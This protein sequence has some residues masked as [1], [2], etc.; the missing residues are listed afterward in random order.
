VTINLPG[1][2]ITH[3]DMLANELSLVLSPAPTPTERPQ[4]KTSQ[5]QRPTIKLSDENLIS[6]QLTGTIDGFGN[7][8][9]RYFQGPN[10][11]I[12][13]LD[14]DFL[15]VQKFITALAARKE[16]SQYVGEKYILDVLFDWFRERYIGK[17]D[18]S[19]G[20]IQYFINRASI[21]ITPLHIAI[22]LSHL[23]MEQSF[24]IGLVT[25]DFY[26]SA[27]FDAMESSFR[28]K[29]PEAAADSLKKIREDYQGIVFAHVTVLAE[30]EHAKDIAIFRTE[31]AISILRLFSPTALFPQAKSYFGRKGHTIIPVDH[32]FL[33]HSDL[34]TILTNVTELGTFN[35]TVDNQLLSL[36]HQG[37]LDIINNL[38]TKDHLSEYEKYLMSAIA[39]FSRSVISS[40][41]NEK[42]VFI[43]ASLETILLKDSTEPIQW[44]LGQRLAF[45]VEKTPER[46][47]HVVTLIKE[48]YQIRSSYLHHGNANNDLEVTTQLTMVVGSAIRVMLA[49]TKSFSAFQDFHNWIEHEIL[50]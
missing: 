12:G 9:S 43:L 3:F 45:I 38:L 35:F 19:F 34:P 32:F 33:F 16:V 31:Q 20:F 23:A 4:P 14:K 27:Y 2:A 50:S 49:R 11:P 6:H 47:K 8:T 46:R 22:P 28:T 24:K 36:M 29:H 26:D 7:Q 13:I 40:D 21:D 30:R 1:P 42:I 17:L 15:R 10:G 39:L 37:G 5:S 48:A 25:F 18:G 41:L 44:S